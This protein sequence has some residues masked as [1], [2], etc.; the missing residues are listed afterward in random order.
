LWYTCGTSDVSSLPEVGGDAVVY[1]NPNDINDI[2]DKIEMVLDDEKLQEE[3][4]QKGLQRAKEFSWEKSA[5][6]HIE[7]FQEVMKF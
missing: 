5:S 7:V 6:K 2:K 4:R 3:L 1:C